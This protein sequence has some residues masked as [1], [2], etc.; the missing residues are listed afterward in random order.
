MIQRRLPLFASLLVLSAAVSARAQ[1]PPVKP[2]PEPPPRAPP[3]TEPPPI[4]DLRLVLNNLFVLRYNPLGIEDQIRFGLQKKL[5]DSESKALRDNFVH[6]GVYP[7]LNPA[8]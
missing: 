3:S 8:F 2:P 7:K 5:Y 1:E 6:L 4:P